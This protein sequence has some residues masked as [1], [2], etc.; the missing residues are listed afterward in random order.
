MRIFNVILLRA[1][2]EAASYLKLTSE[3]L[4]SLVKLSLIV[5]G[6][7]LFFHYRYVLFLTFI[8]QK[9]PLQSYGEPQ[10]ADEEEYFRLAYV[11]VRGYT[12]DYN[13]D[14]S[15]WHLVE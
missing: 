14:D 6:R 8:L 15:S 5:W 11:L 12:Y 2:L 1:S 9:L 3:M 4:I 10:V 13:Q 7:N